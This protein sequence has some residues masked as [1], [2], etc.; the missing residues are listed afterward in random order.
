MPDEV[1]T[2]VEPDGALTVL[3]DGTV[4]EVGWDLQGR[5]MPP[6]EFVEDDVPAQDGS[7]L[8]EVRVRPREVA[9]PIDVMVADTAA[10]RVLMRTLVRKFSPQR[11]DGRLRVL[12]AD[13][14]T[15]ELWCRYRQGLELSEAF[16]AGLGMQRTVVVLRAVDPFWY[17]LTP[18]AATFTSAAPVNFLGDP[19]LPIK[20]SSD[21]ILGEQTVTNDGDVIAWP[22]W[23]VQGPAT[24][25]V[26]TN[27]TTGQVIDL[28]V[29]LTNVQSVTIDTRPFFKTVRRN[30]G[31]NLYG[32]L[33]AAS[34]LW[35]LGSGG[36]TVIRTTVA[37]STAETF[38][39][40]VFS[41]RWLAP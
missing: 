10:L 26:L 2:W 9:L 5:Y 17:D 13:G 36:S 35:A 29:A 28:P 7:R 34:S 24:S 41:R 25:V 27:V 15:R 21:S 20:L 19:F 1:F 30:D 11:G 3:N 16:E 37:G 12:S 31:T 33:T 32:S 4:L 38:V 18:T 8:R 14:T 40:L 6:V 22:V 23:T 39:T